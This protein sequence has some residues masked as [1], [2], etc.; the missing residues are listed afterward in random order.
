MVSGLSPRAGALRRWDGFTA[1]GGEEAAG[2]ATAQRLIR[3][4]RME[5]IEAQLSDARAAVSESRC[6]QQ[7]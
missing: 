6:S 2:A 4:N 1:R 3:V 5:A 7:Y